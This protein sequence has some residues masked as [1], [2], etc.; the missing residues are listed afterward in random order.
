MVLGQVFYDD[1]LMALLPLSIYIST[2]AWFYV[3]WFI[4]IAPVVSIV[5]TVIFVA[6]SCL[7][8]YNFL[9]SWLGDAGIVPRNK[10]LQ[11]RV[12][13]HLIASNW[14]PVCLC[15]RRFWSWLRRAPVVLNLLVFV[16][17]AWCADRYDL[18]IVPSVIIVLLGLIITVHG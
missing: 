10:K 16:L 7:L 13:L 8:W 18:N 12:R 6:S 11:F 1:R 3:T 5:T 2:K 14:V 15:F 4:Y 17:P 9:K